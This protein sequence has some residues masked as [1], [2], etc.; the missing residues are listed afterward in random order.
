M[1]FLGLSVLLLAPCVSTQQILWSKEG[2]GPDSIGPAAWLG[3]ID[4]DG[5]GDVLAVVVHYSGPPEIYQKHLWLISGADG[6]VLRQRGQVEPFRPF[7]GVYA[8]GDVDDDGYAD[9]ITSSYNTQGSPVTVEVHVWSGLDDRLIFEI[10]GGP[11]SFSTNFGWTIVGDLDLNGDGRPDLALTEPLAGLRY[12]TVHA[13]DHRGQK[14]WTV[15][16]TQ[17]EQ[18]GYTRSHAFEAGRMGDLDG[19]GCDDLI[20]RGWDGVQQVPASVVLSGRDGSVLVMGRGDSPQDLWGLTND[21][22][23]DIDGDGTLDWVTGQGGTFALGGARVFSGATG[24]AIWTWRDPAS[25]LGA[26]VT[27]RGMDID[28]DGVPD[29]AV[30]ATAK[31]YPE[32]VATGAV[33]VLSGRDNTRLMML[34]PPAKANRT[35]YMG[36]HLD[37]VPDPGGGFPWLLTWDDLLGG[38][39]ALGRRNC[40]RLILWCLAPLGVTHFGSPCGGQLTRAP[41]IGIRRMLE[42]KTRIQL[43]NGPPGGLAMLL[44]GFSRTSWGSVRLPMALDPFGFP[45]CS[46]LVSLDATALAPISTGPHGGHA[47]VDLPVPL[48]SAIEIHGQWAVFGAGRTPAAGTTDALS[49]HH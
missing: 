16:G 1:R 49:W 39:G 13:Y 30:A 40:G 28:R 20:L 35:R 8:A 25:G 17:A 45:G 23:G 10:D 3:D 2:S 27:G 4:G 42:S 9:Y 29:V 21:G 41:E 47:F 5:I 46:M 37:V 44:L 15:A 19:D 36:R 22:C 48:G 34:W 12:G 26:D 14:L 7:G 18:F 24:R 6:R 38:C 43:R 11:G 32:Y 33:E 31:V